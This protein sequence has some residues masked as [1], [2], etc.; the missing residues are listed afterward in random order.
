MSSY[1]STCIANFLYIFICL[2]FS[3]P[4]IMEQITSILLLDWKYLYIFGNYL[5][6]KNKFPPDFDVLY[7]VS[8][9]H[10]Y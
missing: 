2:Q 5:S 9:C 8:G 1:F 10:F 3:A 6:N 4:R 7:F